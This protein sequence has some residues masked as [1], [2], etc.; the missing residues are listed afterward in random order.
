MRGYFG[1]GIEGVSKPM[2]VG[3][4]MRTA[5]AFGAG[6]LFTVAADYSR[7]EGANADTSDAPSQVPYYAFP[8]VETMVMPAGCELV[9]IELLDD[10]VDLPAFQHP[11]RAAYVLGSERGSLSPAMLERCA[12]VVRI[13]TSFCINVAL[14]GAL[15]MYD[16]LIAH[17]R[18]AA[19][20]T[21]TAT[22]AGHVHGRPKFRTPERMALYQTK[23]PA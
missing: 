1:I 7:G 11:L 16:R 20:G 18:F 3:S 13:P 10:A 15:V 19:R 22:A 23:L 14:A 21:H 9:G 5:H 17:G 4:L 2:N 8:Q 6:F 12:H